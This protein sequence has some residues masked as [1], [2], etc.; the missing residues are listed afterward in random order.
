MRGYCPLRVCLQQELDECRVR[1][2]IAGGVEFVRPPAKGQPL[3]RLNRLDSQREGAADVARLGEL[4]GQG[5][6]RR[7]RLVEARLEPGARIP[8]SH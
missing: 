1:E 2:V 6:A 7:E 4:P 8:P 3:R 5:S